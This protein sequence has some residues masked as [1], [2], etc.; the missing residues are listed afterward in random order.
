MRRRGRVHWSGSAPLGELQELGTGPV[1]DHR[2]RPLVAL[3]EELELAG[4][5]PQQR[6][7]LVLAERV[8]K[9]ITRDRQS[10]AG[11]VLTELRVPGVLLLVGVD[12]TL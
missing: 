1:V 7:N 4:R 12:G 5:N 10:V 8:T 6:G 2:D 3:K 11:E 9:Q